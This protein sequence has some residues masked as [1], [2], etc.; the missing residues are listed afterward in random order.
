MKE[1]GK[2]VF[3][4]VIFIAAAIFWLIN[5]LGYLPN[6]EMGH[7]VFSVIWGAMVVNGLVH[8]E[9]FGVFMGLA[10]LAIVW[11]KELKIEAIT[12]WPVIGAAILLTIGWSLL[13]KGKGRRKW[14]RNYSHG[15]HDR[16]RHLFRKNANSNDEKDGENESHADGEYIFHENRYSAAQKYIDSQNLKSVEIINK[17]GAIDVYLDS[18]KAAG[19]T[20]YMRVECSAGAMNTYIP[21]NWNVE[22]HIECFGSAIDEPENQDVAVNDVTLILSGTVRASAFGIERV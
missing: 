15:F 19:D 11:D 10:F 5:E 14:K 8:R 9:S 13:F 2:N 17:A 7:I 12:P 21:R 3:W 22:N 20:V 6:I 18:A 4:G 16:D 1:R